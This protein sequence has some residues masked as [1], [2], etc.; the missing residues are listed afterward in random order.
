[1]KTQ[2]ITTTL[3]FSLL[4]FLGCQKESL[5][6]IAE[7]KKD[8][9]TAE[10][11]EIVRFTNLTENSTEYI[12]DFGD[13]SVSTGIDPTHV[14][15]EVGTYTVKL[16]ALGKGSKDVSTENIV[17]EPAFI[18]IEPGVRAG[19][20]YLKDDLKTHF[21]KLEEDKM[22]YRISETSVGYLHRFDFRYA[23][24]SFLLSTPTEDYRL[25]YAPN[26]INVSS[27]F[28]CQT[29]GAITYGRSFEEIES[30]FG[31]PNFIAESNEAE[32][33]TGGY[34][35]DGIIF[36]SLPWDPSLNKIAVYAQ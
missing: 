5:P 34:F 17:I 12:W 20:F 7:F 32:L 36:Y 16:I 27:P 25:D 2:S 28:R 26:Q 1:M 3:I 9:A 10:V 11:G 6:P 33:R 21:A 15:E 14:Y 4:I 30:V 35:Y 31:I 29:K 13:G 24:I 8:K 22:D 19:D 18:N 23:G